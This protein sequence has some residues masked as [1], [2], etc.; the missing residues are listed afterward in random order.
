MIMSLISYPTFS[1]FFNRNATLEFFEPVEDN[2][3]QTFGNVVVNDDP[4]LMG[5]S[6]H[7][8][9]RLPLVFTFFHS[10]SIPLCINLFLSFSSLRFF[11]LVDN[12]SIHPMSRRC[13]RRLA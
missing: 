1:D 11:P 12:N 10:P 6:R 5:L 2:V 3:F 7:V 9:S 13:V 8:R 4:N